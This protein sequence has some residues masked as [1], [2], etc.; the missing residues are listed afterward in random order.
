MEGNVL[1]KKAISNL[2]N[3]LSEEEYFLG[4]DLEEATG[5]WLS[6]TEPEGQLAVDVYQTEK[7]IVIKAPVAGVSEN[8]ID[9]SVLPEQVNIR[10]E[11][12]EEHEVT[13]DKYHSKECFWGAFSRMIMLPVEGDPEG[14][15]ATFKNGILT[16]RVPKAKRSNGV[17]LRVSHT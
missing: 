6:G 9:I 4:T 16:I 1:V 15:H 14:S 2:K 12:K 5:D 7:D 11:R 3:Q 8:D 17:K 10:G 13:E